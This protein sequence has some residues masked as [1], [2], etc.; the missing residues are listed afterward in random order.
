MRKGNSLNCW[1]LALE[2]G[3]ASQR[4][5]RANCRQAWN[6]VLA[7][8]V[9]MREENN[10]EKG[11]SPKAP[12]GPFW[13]FS[14]SK[15]LELIISLGSKLSSE[16]F[17]LNQSVAPPRRH[18]EKV[19]H[20]IG[21]RIA[22]KPSEMMFLFLFRSFA[23]EPQPRCRTWVSSLFLLLNGCIASQRTLEKTSPTAG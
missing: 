3:Q 9:G 11:N 23:A 6:H 17:N 10:F 5:N 7:L 22:E 13:M 18:P 1:A 2:S 16:F 20:G 8:G 19:L 4:E 21:H 15:K 12:L 14:S